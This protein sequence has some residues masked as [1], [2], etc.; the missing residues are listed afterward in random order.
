MLA[1]CSDDRTVKLWDIGAAQEA[2]T[3]R[4][5][6]TEIF[7]LAFSPDG[8]TLATASHDTTARLWDLSTKSE[9]AALSATRRTLAEWTPPELA[10][11]FRITRENEPRPAKILEPKIPWWRA[12]M[13]AEWLHVRDGLG[14][15]AYWR[16]GT[17]KKI[18]VIFAGPGTNLLVALGL[19]TVLL[20]QDAWQIGVR[21]EAA[22]DGAATTRIAEVLPGTPAED[23]GLLAGDRIVGVDGTSVGAR[24]LLERIADSEGRPLELTVR[25]GEDTLVTRVAAERRRPSVGRL[26]LARSMP[27]DGGT[28]T[29]GTRPSIASRV[30]ANSRP[31]SSRL[32]IR[33]VSAKPKTFG[34]SSSMKRVVA[35]E[36][37]ASTLA[38]SSKSAWPR[39]T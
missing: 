32:P 25:R 19:F 18:A 31:S 13:P 30:T 6:G 26:S 4:G 8:K 5:H 16:Q 10:L 23:A 39:F 14:R 33:A 22:A 15:D 11:G 28:T 36:E 21:L 12:P 1:T 9:I 2:A 34:R 37:G 24:R 17:W 38:K 35:S 3:L 27:S 7:S 29:M 20:M